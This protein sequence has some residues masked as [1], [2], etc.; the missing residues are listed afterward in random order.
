MWLLFQGGLNSLSTPYLTNKHVRDI[1][2][3]AHKH[4]LKTIGITLGPWG[5]AKRWRGADGFDALRRTRLVV[6]FIMGRLTPTEA[7]ERHAKGRTEWSTGE[8]PTIA[9]DMFD[10]KLRDRD[11]LPLSDKRLRHRL[12]YD[13]RI[14]A[15]LRR[16]PKALRES[17]LDRLE[18]DAR[19]LSKQFM[20]PAL[21]AF[22]SIHPNTEGHRVMA[23]AICPKVPASWGCSCDA[24][25]NMRWDKDKRGLTPRVE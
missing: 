23:E 1:F 24:L 2:L 9:V 21:M 12:R 19:G 18:Q 14:S 13:K 6:D 25:P 10:S 15:E 4:G 20:R 5:N 22:D 16:L 3:R 11:A 17:A 7:L 8:L